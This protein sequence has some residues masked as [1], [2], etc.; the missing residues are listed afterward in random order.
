MR[1]LQSNSTAAVVILN[2]NGEGFLGEFLPFVLERSGVGVEIVVVD[3]G[4][5]DGSLAVLRGFWGMVRVIELG[6]NHG[7]A[8]G[9]NLGLER[10][11]EVNPGL[12]YYILLNSDVEVTEGWEGALIELMQCD[13][14]V[15]AV[16]PKIRSYC[17]KSSFEHAGASGGFIDSLGYPFCRGRI[18]NH[19]EE[20]NGQYDS[21]R[22]IFWSTGA[23]MGVR[24]GVFHRCGGFDALFF[25]HMEEIDLCWRMK[26]MGYR[27]M[28]APGS[29][30]YHVGGGTLPV[31]SPR[32]THLNF[33]NNIAMLYKN[34][35]LGRFIAVYTVRL[36][37]DV[38]TATAY[39]VVGKWRFTTAILRAHRDFWKMRRKLNKNPEMPK[40][41]VN[42]VYHGSIIVRYLFGKKTFKDLL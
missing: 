17:K 39:T 30:V 26:R 34:L 33:R 12:E 18:L 31:G 21:E 2:W 41:K 5:T 15:A 42:G 35:T 32:K 11:R 6:E 16:Q 40:P 38:A 28:V 20:D 22:D 13:A 4:S 23:A 14:T 25:A 27:V 8:G 1:T 36:W 19:C 24:A 7:F 3:N 10:L 9:Y 29:V 37:L